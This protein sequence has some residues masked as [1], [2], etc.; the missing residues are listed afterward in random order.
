M[1][2]LKRKSKKHEEIS[3]YLESRFSKNFFK[4]EYNIGNNLFLDIYIESIGLAI[5]IDGIQHDF[6]I[7]FFHGDESNF[8]LQKFR[9]SK[10][11]RLCKEQSV[12][13]F[14]VK[15]DDN[16]TAEEIVN[17]A[18]SQNKKRLDSMTIFS[19]DRMLCVTCNRISYFDENN[20]C[21]SCLSKN[22]KIKNM[23]EKMLFDNNKWNRTGFKKEYRKTIKDKSN[24]T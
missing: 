9:D 21:L 12:F 8:V 20:E 10:K 2:N 14:R 7:P 13:L 3:N 5:E 16:R 11:D 6:F 18:I 23:K 22:K 4:E 19:N 24:N 1:N 15:F 17:E